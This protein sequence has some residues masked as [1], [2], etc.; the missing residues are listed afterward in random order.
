MRFVSIADAWCTQGKSKKV[1]REEVAL[2]MTVLNISLQCR[3]EDS[4]LQA[5]YPPQDYPGFLRPLG[6]ERA[7][8]A[9][10]TGLATSTFFLYAAPCRA[11]NTRAW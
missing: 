8:P 7:L 10:F 9:A 1:E 11:R 5:A 3:G 2:T 6:S 4:N